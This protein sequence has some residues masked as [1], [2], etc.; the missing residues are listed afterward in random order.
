MLKTQLRSKIFQLNPK[1]RDIED[2]LT[3]DYFG[4]LDYL[5][6]R[7]YLR[8]LL[9]YVIQLNAEARAPE[10]ND[11]DWDGVEFLFWPLKYTEEEGAE[12]DLVL[13]SNR[14]VIVVEVKLGSGLGERQPWRE[15]VIGKDIAAERGISSDGVHYLV[16]ARGH[17]DVAATFSDSDESQKTEL[18]SRTS[19]LRWS[20]AAGLVESWLRRGVHG[21]DC[22]GEQSRMLTDLLD[23]MRRRRALVFSG[24]SFV[25]QED[26]AEFRAR[27]FCPALFA[28]F[29]S[30]S[31]GP[32]VPQGAGVFFSRFAGFLPDTRSGNARCGTF[33]GASGFSG[34]MAGTPETSASDGAFIEAA[35]FRGFLLSGRDCPAKSEAWLLS[36]EILE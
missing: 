3:G 33:L 34:F 27:V 36:G 2:I 18:L 10:L 30:Q 1:W 5:P 4:T 17:P 31:D 12:P 29:L 15:Y 19:H 8:A 16:V 21:Q 28:G 14:W 9:S 26:V 35:R 20:E 22:S 6:R 7:P 23:V 32:A 11:V 24:F 25:N 13:V